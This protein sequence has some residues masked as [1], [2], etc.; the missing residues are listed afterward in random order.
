M[1]RLSKI[2]LVFILLVFFTL[3]AIFILGADKVL[4]P[5][6]FYHIRH[7]WL[8]RTSG[9]FQTDFPWV[10]FSVIRSNAA[11]IWYGFHLLLIPFTF[12]DNLVEGIY[13]SAIFFAATA[14]AVFYFVLRRHRIAYSFLWVI[15]LYF[16]TPDFI[17]RLNMS[18]P[19]TI[20]IGLLAL[21]FSFLVKPVGIWPIF[22]VSAAL[23]FIHL[24]FFWAAIL[25]AVMVMVTIFIIQKRLEWKNP[26]A[27]FGGIV[28]GWLLRPNP[29]GA[30]KILKVQ[31]VDLLAVKQAG[32]PLLFGEEL[33]PLIF[34]AARYKLIP[35]L[36]LWGIGIAILIWIMRKRIFTADA[37]T[38]VFIFGSLVNAIVFFLLAI[39]S[40]QRATDFMAMFGIFFV[41]SLIFWWMA[42]RKNHFIK[43]SAGFNAVIL[44]I[45]AI[46][47]IMVFRHT[48]IFNTYANADYVSQPD[49]LKEVSLWLRDNSQSGEIVF[50]TSWDSFPA[51]FFWNQK[52][53][54]INGMDPIFEYSFSPSLYWEHNIMAVS[55]RRFT[56]GVLPCNEKSGKSLWEAMR[57]DFGASYAI[58]ELDRNPS[59]N[60]NLESDLRFSKVFSNKSEVIYRIKI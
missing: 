10:Q 20:S 1:N 28:V 54:Y 21:L 30:L 29:F 46:F 50:H 8:Y 15:L 27:L 49:R 57:K 5:D 34:E 32:L 33:R 23:T 47:L 38:K 36:V 45:A 22:A 2:K 19:Q 41:A 52:N 17:F 11:D 55:G 58:I 59:L 16:S 4:D 56:C 60:L 3:P 6:S 31:L 18:R 35:F 53:Y 7:A 39:F 43:S 14:L 12:F 37:Q 48:V 25:I 44:G 51:L 24:S 9:I 26:S 13:F 42:Y 40:G